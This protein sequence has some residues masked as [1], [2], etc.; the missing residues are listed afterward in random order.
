[1][2][3]DMLE[4]NQLWKDAI[5]YRKRTTELDPMNWIA[6]MSLARDLENTGDKTGAKLALK[7]VLEFTNDSKFIDDAK[8]GLL[9]LGS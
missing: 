5:P 7:K 6:W 4:K 1:M 3:V 8:S 2:V 9:R